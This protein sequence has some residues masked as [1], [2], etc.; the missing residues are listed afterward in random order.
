M[1]GE[2]PSGLVGLIRTVY[3]PLIVW[4]LGVPSGLRN[5]IRKE[6]ELSGATAKRGAVGLAGLNG[7]TSPWGPRTR[8]M[9]APVKVAG[10]MSRSK[11]MS[12][13]SVALLTTT[14]VV[15]MVS[16]H[17]F[18]TALSLALVSRTSS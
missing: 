15:A 4:T 18:R 16:D 3:C 6:R 8:R 17:S 14:R 10:S 9:L 2:T 12:V 13:W 7:E 1:G 11:V 5:V